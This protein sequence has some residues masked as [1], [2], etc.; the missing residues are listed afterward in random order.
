[1]KRFFV[2]I[3]AI[4]FVFTMVAAIT[5]HAEVKP[6]DKPITLEN[7]KAPV[8]FDHSTHTDIKCETC[9]HMWKDTSTAPQK[10]EDC[11]KPK[12]QG[13]VPK[14]YNMAHKTDRS[15]RGCHKAFKKAGKKTG[16]TKC[17]GCHKK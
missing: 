17:T 13:D 2:G 15:C 14:R 16:P 1:M 7:N 8:T 11:H 6:P 10:C 9:H 3:L 4:M 5:A 12:K